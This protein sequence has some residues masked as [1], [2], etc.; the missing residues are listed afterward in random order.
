MELNIMWKI[1]MNIRALNSLKTHKMPIFIIG[2]NSVCCYGTIHYKSIY[3][4][5]FCFF[6][7][8]FIILLW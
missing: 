3:L 2:A 5:G 7:K 6:I 4:T 8:L 1:R